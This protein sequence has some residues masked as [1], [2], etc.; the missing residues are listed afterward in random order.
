MGRSITL[1]LERDLMNLLKVCTSRL[2]FAA[3]LGLL[4]LGAASDVAAFEFFSW[5][6]ENASCQAVSK[7]D[8]H[9]CDC[10]GQPAKENLFKRSMHAL[11]GHLHALL[12]SRAGCDE[13]PC[14]DACDAMMLEELMEMQDS[15]ESDPAS[16]QPSSSD[17][18]ENA[19]AASTQPASGTGAV[20]IV[21]PLGAAAAR[22]VN[23]EPPVSDQIEP[24]ERSL[25]EFPGGRIRFSSPHITVP[26]TAER[27]ESIAIP[28]PIRTDS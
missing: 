5:R 13:I 3:M 17:K 11:M 19:K 8:C 20:V 24:R 14:D 27:S 25:E 22:D 9:Q 18:V 4:T 28:L 6:A 10:A 26:A 21:A 7:C 16:S 15:L 2:I 23:T 12:P 1:H